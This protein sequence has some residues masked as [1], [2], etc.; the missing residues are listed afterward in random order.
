MLVKRLADGVPR[1]VA[2][3]SVQH[4]WPAYRDALTT[5]L[6][7]NPLPGALKHPTHPTAVVL[8]DAD[9]RADA[10]AVAAVMPRRA[11]CS[12]IRMKP[13]PSSS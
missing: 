13:S 2:R 8:A 3:E 5:L 11:T 4:S 10:P 6:D 12:T 1:E 9:L 7:S